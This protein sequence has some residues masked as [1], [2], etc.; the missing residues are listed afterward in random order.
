MPAGRPTPS[1]DDVIVAPDP[2]PVRKTVVGQNDALLSLSQT[3]AHQPDKAMARLAESALKLTRAD[4]A[5]ISIED[6]EDGEPVFRWIATCGAFSQYV[7]GT[8]PRDFSPCGTVVKRGRTLV[9]QQP[10]RHFD[11]VAQIQPPIHMALLAPFGRRGKLIGTV[12]VLSHRAD[13]RFTERDVGNVQ[14]LTTFATAILD[15]MDRGS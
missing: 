13:K 5:G 12:W 3:L 15:A 7:N 9:M 2:A 11:Y 8:M 10:A 6:M 1:V 14:D 4:S